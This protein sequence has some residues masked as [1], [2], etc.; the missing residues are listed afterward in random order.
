MSRAAPPNLQGQ[1]LTDYQEMNGRDTVAEQV[2]AAR[3]DD[4]T[5]EQM[6][7]FRKML[8]E[9]KTTSESTTRVKLAEAPECNGTGYMGKLRVRTSFGAYG[10]EVD[11]EMDPTVAMLWAENLVIAAH[12][13]QAD[14]QRAID[15]DKRA[16]PVS[17]GVSEAEGGG[18]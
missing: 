13:A 9:P 10:H 3:A 2:E 5:R 17:M 11:I 14:R 12:Q 8:D 18:A 16:R 1:A 6:Q 7:E 4:V 15:E